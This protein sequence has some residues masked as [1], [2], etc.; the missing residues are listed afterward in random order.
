M[1]LA[2]ALT[3]AALG[4]LVLAAV[5]FYL[6]FRER[7]RRQAEEE[8]LREANFE[9]QVLG[10]FGG[11]SVDTVFRTAYSSEVY[12]AVETMEFQSLQGV[13]LHS[14]PRES[15]AS[16]EAQAEDYYRQPADVAAEGVLRQLQQAGLVEQLEGYQEINGNPKAAVILRL[17]GGKRALL[18]PYFETEA[19]VQ[20]NAKRFELLVFVSRSGK[21]TVLSPME[22][23]I[24]SRIAG[25]M[26]GF[27][28]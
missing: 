15:A 7:L 28:H 22:E 21:A 23:M 20:R 8:R 9:A 6:V 19:F 13:P 27:Q 11:S 1:D 5:G 26:G 12:P 25:R 16:V 17:R 3:Y 24:A 14:A 4:L 10:S 18:V 2:D